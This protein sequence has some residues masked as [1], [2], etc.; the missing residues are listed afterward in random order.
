MTERFH[1]G[2][3]ADQ[4]HSAAGQLDVCHGRQA[5]WANLPRTLLMGVSILF[6]AKKWFLGTGCTSVACQRVVFY[7][8]HV[9]Y[10]VRTSGQ[11][12]VPKAVIPSVAWFA[13]NGHH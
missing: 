2:A 9:K 8:A 12:L 4:V 11:R 7:V 5:A 6:M 10:L 3:G 13:S 1:P